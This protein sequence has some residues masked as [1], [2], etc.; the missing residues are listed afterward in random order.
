MQA[1]ND[2]DMTGCYPQPPVPQPVNCGTSSLGIHPPVTIRGTVLG[3]TGI[4]V[5]GACVYWYTSW[6]NGSSSTDSSGLFA[7]NV[8]A[9]AQVTALIATK[10]L[11]TW[12]EEDIVATDYVVDPTKRAGFH[13][14]Y[15]HSARVTPW[16]I[17]STQD[18]QVL[19]ELFTG[20][21]SATSRPLVHVPNGPI[22][23]LSQ[24]TSYSNASGIYRWTATATVTSGL[25]EGLKKFASCVLTTGT[26]DTCT[27]PGQSV[28][29][30]GVPPDDLKA[31]MVVDNTPPVFGSS[32]PPSNHLTL[33]LR[34][35]IYIPANDYGSG[36]VGDLYLDGTR[37]NAGG[38]YYSPATDLSLG[39][40]GVSATATDAAGNAASYGWQFEV[41]QLE[42]DAAIAQFAATST[43]VTPAPGGLSGK[44]TFAPIPVTLA[45]YGLNLSSSTLANG[46]G[47]GVRNVNYGGLVVTFV[48]ELGQRM[49][50]VASV[51]LLAY[52]TTFAVLAPDSSAIK[53]RIPAAV[54]S[55]PSFTVDT[56]AGFIVTDHSRALL[57]QT[58]AGAG[59][60]WLNVG[61]DWADPL[62]INSDEDCKNAACNVTGSVS[63]DFQSP[64]SGCLGVSPMIML[65]IAGQSRLIPVLGLFPDADDL[66][67]G[68]AGSSPSKTALKKP[69]PNPFTNCGSGYGCD[70]LV[71]PRP[72][73][74]IHPPDK[75]GRLETYWRAGELFKAFGHHYPY[76]V[77][78][79][80]SEALAV[81]Q[82]SDALSGSDSGRISCLTSFGHSVESLNDRWAVGRWSPTGPWD[83]THL[84]NSVNH[85]NGEYLPKLISGAYELSV[86]EN[87]GVAMSP[88]ANPDK[89]GYLGGTFDAQEN[90]VLD[91]LGNQ[92][93]SVGT[94]NTWA[95]LS[96]VRS[97]QAEV[98]TATEFLATSGTTASLRFRLFFSFEVK[99][100]SA[101]G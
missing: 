6:G 92:V 85:P 10:S 68:A 77:S 4:G 42:A 53:A 99:E 89:P 17:N 91:R 12:D 30:S 65:Q 2:F 83:E 49:P 27:S 70:N 97:T 48:N 8:A 3:P 69:D 28:I 73:D 43:A 41:V 96:A 61:P 18:R 39:V 62:A 13:I 66:V 71:A 7:I 47:R 15:T 20:A 37:V 45:E 1:C 25:T 5:A 51:P 36:F 34:P 98:M 44:A 64:A 95:P 75:W 50:N 60:I 72:G 80:T 67:T 52:E 11:M 26:Q 59:P 19:V 63:C 31:R 9:D 88:L 22:A 81:W 84:I 79:A 40:H 78:G 74:Q 100:A 38:L 23:Q 14:A 87:K 24:D 90:F 101:C 35:W 56:P 21:P 76:Q 58:N 29:L 32:T 54:Q 57:N 94:F 46:R 55:L 33:S 16:A 86:P 93:P 82:G